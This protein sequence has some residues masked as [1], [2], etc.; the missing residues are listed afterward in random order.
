MG[1]IKINDKKVFL[2]EPDK[3]Q[4]VI[5]STEEREIGVWTDGKPLYAISTSVTVS[6]NDTWYGSDFNLNTSD[7]DKVVE[8]KGSF[9][10]DSDKWAI[11]LTYY[12]ASNSFSTHVAEPN[13]NTGKYQFE[14]KTKAGAG[15][16]YATLYYTKTTDTAGSGKWTPQGVP[17]VHYSTDEHIVGTWIDGKTLY[18]CTC[19]SNYT[20]VSGTNWQ[21]TDIYLGDKNIDLIT[22]AQ[23]LRVGGDSYVIFDVIGQYGISASEYLQITNIVSTPNEVLYCI[24]IQY[25]KSS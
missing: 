14:Y 7:I 19:M 16:V 22:N 12:E 24:T 3:F 2:L 9:I 18:E 11:A 25:T 10:R 17:A 4:P 6:S 1:T 8:I 20:T 15:K 5:Y 21:V 23:A 13:T